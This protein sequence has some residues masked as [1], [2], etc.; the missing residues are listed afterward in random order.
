MTI[1]EQKRNLYL[2]KVLTGEEKGVLA[3][4]PSL[5]K[6]WLKMYSDKQIMA[7]VPEMTAYQYMYE[8]NKLRK[9][10]KALNYFGYTVT[11]GQLFDK[12]DEMVKS[13]T[14]LGV[15]QGDTVC[16]CC[17]N[18]P[19]I[20]YL[21]YAISKIGA[22]ADIIDPRINEN[23]MYK[24]LSDVNAKLFLCLDLSLPKYYGIIDKTSVEKVVSLPVLEALPAPMKAFAVAKQVI[25]AKKNNLPLP[26]KVV[27]PKND[28]YMTFSEFKKQGKNGFVVEAPYEKN[29]AVAIIHTG[30][31]TG[32]PK[33]AVLSNDNLNSLAHQL[34]NTNLEFNAGQ[35]WLSLMPP[36]VAYGL[37]NGMHLSLSCGMQSILIPTYEPDKIDEMLLKWKPNRLACSPAHWE[38]FARSEK[39]RGQDLSYL[40]NPIEGGDSINIELEKQVNEILRKQGCKDALRKGYGLSETCAALSVA[41]PDVAPEHLHQS[42]GYPLVNTNMGIFEPIDPEKDADINDIVELG[43]NQ[44]GEVCTQTDNVM[45]GYFNRPEENARTLRLHPDGKVWLHTGDLGLITEDGRLFI[46]GRTKRIVIRFDG[47]KV[48]PADIE[49]VIAKHPAVSLVAVVGVKDSSHE[50][51]ELPKAYIVLKDGYKNNPEIIEQI[52][53]LCNQNLI[54]YMIPFAYEE[55]D[56]MLYTPLGKPDFMSLKKLQT[57]TG[58]KELSRKRTN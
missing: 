29:R 45:L 49:S 58:I 55:I 41:S 36:C 20:V 33:G 17:T 12:I 28:K 4:K 24:Y 39:L 47:T 48:Y 37:A 51:G 10:E 50:Q 9:K 1:E 34:R 57:E 8:N 14:S 35:T 44:I 56:K 3:G 54:D 42:V 22:V 21:F 7:P 16:I 38:Y 15:K 26:P 11:Y 53:M 23:V 6:P 18:T 19:E 52:A 25:D 32:I 13:L 27:L 40:I 31:T 5:D 43:Y 46:K 30:G 2:K